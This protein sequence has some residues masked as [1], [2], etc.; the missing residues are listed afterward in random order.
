MKVFDSES[1]RN[2]AVVGHGDAGKT[3]L[4][5]ALLYSAGAVNRLGRVED[6]NTVTDYD[7]DEIERKITIN[8]S[9]A[10]LIWKDTKINL[11]DTPGYGAFILDTKASMIAAETA[12]V[13]VEAVSGVGVQTE[14][15][16]SFA[17]EFGLPRV[18][19]VNKM[20][21]DR[22]SFSRSLESIQELFGRTSV[23]V[24]L[25]IGEEKEFRGVV[26]LVRNKAYLFST[27][28]S[29]NFEEV[30]IPEE[31][32]AVAAKS[33]DQLVEMIAESD[34]ALMEK[35]FEQGGLSEAELV[36]GL[37]KSIQSLKI[38]PVFCASATL[39]MG[40]KPLLDAI[41]A[42]LPGPL[43]R[44]PV[45]LRDLKTKQ[46]REFAISKE[47]PAAA[48]VFKT[49]AD[50]FAGRI[51]MLKVFGG[52][53]KS[54]TTYRNFSRDIDERVGSLQ[55]LQG[56]SHEAVSEVRAGDVC[57]VL[58][59]KEAT[60]GDTLADR[61]F[62]AAFRSVEF[63]EPAI[64][65]AVEPK[66]RGDEDKIGG[67][68][69]RIIEEDPSIGFRRDPQTKEF[70][71]SGT[72][73]LHVEVAVAKLKKKYGVEVVLKPPKVPYR[74]TITGTADVQGRHKKQTGGHG[75]FGDCK[76]KME[77]LP[78]DS[79]LQ[80]ED[81]IFGGAIPRNY[82]PAVEKGIVE[83]AEKGFLA[84]FPVVD[85]KV[86]LY[87]GSYHEVD[88]SELAF[89][90]AGSLAFKKGMEMA[91]PVL[92]E[93]IMNVEVYAPE[94]DAGDLMGD[95]NSRRGRI[96]GMDSRGHVQIIRA[97]VPLSEMLNYSSA[98]TSMTGGRGSYHMENSH[99]DIVPAHLA[100]RI[101]AEAR[102]EKEEKSA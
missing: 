95:L 71:L 21:R 78:R 100:E 37:R 11:L 54:D 46:E 5:S 17:E 66:S 25:P 55:I 7:E 65:F 31:V 102:K 97:Q 91:K 83:A 10:Y 2:V 6:G 36:T 59:L 13:V 30:D 87:D 88:S 69:A 9:L 58:K 14:N 62:A 56:K 96:Q 38:F 72:G 101:I 77:P 81:A 75:Q 4:V 86:I 90:I 92:L 57:T 67:A 45:Q 85:F 1:I 51:S 99:Y 64:S 47:G 49:L 50:P 98:L 40:G 89:K 22:A 28:P 74:E 24:Q 26:D 3:S 23:P 44:G 53:L 94:E 52:T 42:F 70:L 35:F 19:V 79:G 43:E 16:W 93:P 29:G 80:F 76:I 8:T 12:L 33:R 27:D 32:R 61:S 18:L 41:Q 20:D 15:V 34:D 60:T 68:I 84:G 73:Q 39:N 82:I 48:F 63:P